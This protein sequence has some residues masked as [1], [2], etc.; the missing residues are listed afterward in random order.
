MTQQLDYADLISVTLHDDNIREFYTRWDEVL[1]SV[2]KIPS[3]DV[4]ESLYKFENTWVRATQNCIGIVRHVDSSEDIGSQQSKVE[5]HGKEWYKS[6][7]SITKLWRHPLEIWF[8][9]SDK[10]SKGTDR[11]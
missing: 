11:R 6:E 5:D 9:S 3:D 1:L 2:S 8:R 7:T 4:F 10:E